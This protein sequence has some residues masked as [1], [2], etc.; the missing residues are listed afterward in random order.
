M[1]K[2]LLISLDTRPEQ[3]AI[4]EFKA[5]FHMIKAK[6]YQLLQTPWRPRTHDIK[7][8]DVYELSVGTS[9]LSRCDAICFCTDWNTV[10][11]FKVIHDIAIQ[12]DI[13]IFYI[14]QSGGDKFEMVKR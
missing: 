10:K 4:V 9:M 12:Y 5:I 3:E 6:G 1:K 2:I 8:Q 13:P 11:E 14:K 7:H